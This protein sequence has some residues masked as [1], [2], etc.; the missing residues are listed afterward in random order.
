[1]WALAAAWPGQLA[2]ASLSTER[3]VL[4]SRLSPSPSFRHHSAPPCTGGTA[5]AGSGQGTPGD[6]QQAS[7]QV[8]CADPSRAHGPASHRA[9][10]TVT[11][12]LQSHEA[13]HEESLVLG[14]SELPPPK[15]LRIL[16]ASGWRCP[17]PGVF[18]PM[19]S[20]NP[21]VSVCLSCPWR[22]QL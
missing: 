17:L 5:Q 11:A 20:I 2:L 7:G 8:G 16:T 22:R 13:T 3:T 15:H 10:T 19:F 21:S 9:V 14:R 1:M 6:L 4:G 18:A 12:P